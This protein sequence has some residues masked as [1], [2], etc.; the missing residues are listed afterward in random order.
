MPR[1]SRLT[2]KKILI[3]FASIIQLLSCLTV[4]LEVIVVLLHHVIPSKISEPSKILRLKLCR[5]PEVR[6][7]VPGDEKERN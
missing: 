5:F 3:P 2:F 6:R 7:P 4:G 1:Q